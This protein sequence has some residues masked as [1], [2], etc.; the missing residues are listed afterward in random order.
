MPAR[1]DEFRDL[2]LSEYP[3]VASYCWHLL[4]DRE[5]ADE[6]AQEAFTRLFAKWVKVQ[7]PRHYVYR[8]ATNLIRDSW[9]SRRRQQDA[10]QAMQTDAARP[11]SPPDL[12]ATLAVQAAV[13]ALPERLRPVVLLHYYADLSIAD[14]AIALDRPDGSIKR[15]LSEA[16][17][18]LA[19]ELDEESRHA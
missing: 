3:G 17:A 5:L 12:A 4:R 8:I 19:T 16:R 2:Y 14:I 10:T 15:Q 18:L 7:Q 9:S 13:Q 1:T 6:T 11:V